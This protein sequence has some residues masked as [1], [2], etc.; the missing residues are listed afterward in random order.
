MCLIEGR[1]VGG[2]LSALYY[3]DDPQL[4]QLEEPHEP[5]DD[6]CELVKPLSLLWLQTERSFFTL[7]PW[8]VGQETS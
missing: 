2:N 4:E 7:V 6:P 1:E 5:Q 3:D 8:Q